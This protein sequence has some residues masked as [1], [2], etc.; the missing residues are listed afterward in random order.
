MM[1][2]P[3]EELA[4]VPVPMAHLAAVFSLMAD[5]TGSSTVD[6][7]VEQSPL[8]GGTLGG[9]LGN[10]PWTVAELAQIALGTMATTKLVTRMM[11]VLAEQPGERYSTTD[12]VERL[13]VARTSLRGALAALTRH[14]KKHYPEHSWPFQWEWG[15]DLGEGFEAE[16]YYSI[17]PEMAVTWTEAR[18]A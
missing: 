3:T 2:H 8:P 9:A 12:L 10:A 5:L 15:V 4:Y 1:I 16:M 14:V 17:E 7:S 13:G 18:R 6:V 11:D